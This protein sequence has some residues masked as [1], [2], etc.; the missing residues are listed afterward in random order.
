VLGADNYFPQKFEL[1]NKQVI[2]T[3]YHIAGSG[4]AN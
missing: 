4:Q 2:K 1:A 3:G